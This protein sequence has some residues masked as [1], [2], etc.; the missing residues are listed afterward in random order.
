MDRR[1]LVLAVCWV[2]LLTVP[3]ALAEEAPDIDAIVDAVGHCLVKVSVYPQYSE[4]KGPQDDDRYYY[5]SRWAASVDADVLSSALSHDRPLEVPGFLVSS[6]RVVVQDFSVHPRFIKRVE[7][8]VAGKRYQA[9][10]DA[11]SPRGQ[12][13]IL[14][15]ERPVEG[16]TPLEFDAQAPGPYYQVVL[17]R[18]GPYWVTS[19]T[20]FSEQL[21][22]DD[23]GRKRR[24]VRSHSLVVTGGG[25]PV[26][27]TTSSEVPLDDSW[28]GSPLEQELLP[29]A[30]V[31]L[32][33]EALVEKIDAGVA[34][35]SFRF[36]AP[37]KED[38]SGLF[39]RSR[40]RYWSG[41]DEKDQR[42]RW[43]AGFLLSPQLVLIP[44]KC[45]RD[46]LARLESITVTAQGETADAEF[47]GALEHYHLLLA[48]L[49]SPLAGAQPLKLSPRDLNE[50][51]R[52][53]VLAADM[54]FSH[55]KR[56]VYVQ[57]DRVWNW[58]LGRRGLLH[59]SMGRGTPTTF[60]FDR[61][62]RL[63][64]VPLVTRS[65]QT[66]E[67]RFSGY[68]QALICTAGTVRSFV[69]EPD[70][71]VDASLKPL[72]EREAKML[73]W[74]GV[75]LQPLDE[76]LAQL[77]QVSRQTRGGEFG[78]VITHIYQG[79]PAERV[80]LEVGD[81]LIR[82]T[83]A[84]QPDPMEIE[85]EEHRVPEFPWD[86][87]PGIQV[88]VELL[89]HLPAPWPP[90]RNRLTEALTGIGPGK[91][92]DLSFARDGE[93]KTVALRLELGPEDYHS[94]ELHKSES[95]GATVKGLTYEVRRFYR[96][97]QDAPGVIVS[98]IE[99]GGKAAV[100]GMR[101]Y[102]LVTHV[103]G[104]PVAD[105]EG[106]R[107]ALAPGGVMELTVKYL[108]KTRLIKVTLDSQ[109]SETPPEKAEE[110]EEAEQ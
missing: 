36:R 6:D 40:V 1:A 45:S 69:D 76:Q 19:V 77:N 64:G 93:E 88:P 80:G 24:S 32:M 92:A 109:R 28:K 48:T 53:F 38:E 62:G 90:R 65:R 97:T 59:P 20:P 63:L 72:S 95:L 100:G 60:Y 42:E 58:S 5:G 56:K 33:Q 96:L 91:E 44:I 74:L 15:L 66:D 29:A 84:N 110:A 23:R 55:G 103:N 43:S 83:V 8:E 22:W 86:Q 13:R 31:K 26:G 34:L 87:F 89:Q 41:D 99:T 54:D 79:S 68:G 14:R 107:E 3:V 106:L 108:A 70:E 102:E 7:V 75:E 101:P 51:H 9:H 11:W 16:V 30:D 67:Y 57:H 94:A 50:M 46:A 39:G 85:A 82:L 98:K 52:E 105:L 12:G 104:Q 4:G 73:V 37:P 61:E 81:V 27:V 71:F 78:A 49:S 21:E 17:A 18:E 47:L 25:V 10:T 2:A 35:V